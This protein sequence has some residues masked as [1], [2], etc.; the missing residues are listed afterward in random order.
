[1]AL[2]KTLD[3]SE[4]EFTSIPENLGKRS[5]ILETL[6]LDHNPIE[7]LEIKDTVRV[8]R[9]SMSNMPKVTS[10]DLTNFSRLQGTQPGECFDLTISRCPQLTEVITSQ[11]INLKLCKLD[12]SYNQIERIQSNLTEWKNITKG[13]DL[14]G[15]PLICDCDSQWMLDDI[16]KYLYERRE[17]QYLLLELR[18]ANPLFKNHRFVKYYKRFKAFCYPPDKVERLQAAGIGSLDGD[19]AQIFGLRFKGR[20]N[21]VTVIIFCLVLL[22]VL[23]CFGLY[24]TRQ[25]NKVLSNRNR[26]YKY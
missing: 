6:I 1:M 19:D 2:L 24:W 20:P 17:L 3:I 23:V 26:L 11:P 7:V 4:N 18:C 16:L 9:I 15:N 10:V 21:Y 8:H 22:V 14:Q 25:Q 5:P 13:I 12:L